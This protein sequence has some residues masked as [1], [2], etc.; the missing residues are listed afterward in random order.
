MKM[1]CTGWKHSKGDFDGVAY[2]NLTLYAVAR[3]EQKDTQR[4]AAGIDLKCEV[5]L[6][7]KLQK[8]EWNGVVVCDVET[9]TRATGKGG[10]VEMVINVTPVPKQ[11]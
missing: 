8:I 11:P 1:N 4:G 3:M 10:H 2:D 7:E 6:K 5:S 9:E